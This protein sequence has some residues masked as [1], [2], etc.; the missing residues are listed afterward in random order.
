MNLHPPYTTEEAY[1]KPIEDLIGQ[2]IEYCQMKCKVVKI[3]KYVKP[4]HFKLAGFRC[5]YILK[6]IKPTKQDLENFEDGYLFASS[7]A[8]MFSWEHFS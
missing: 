8:I 3:A 7:E 4:E 1:Y 6:I 5:I 2:T